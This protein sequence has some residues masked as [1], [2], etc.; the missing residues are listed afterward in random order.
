MVVYNPDLA[1]PFAQWEEVDV[2]FPA[3]AN[4]DLIIR[5][6]LLPTLPEQV[7]YIPIRK[8]QAGDVYHDTT[9]TRVP[10]QLGYI[11]LR[12][13]VASAKVTLLLYVGHP[14]RT[15]VF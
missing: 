8:G 9:G 10:W 12:C 15:V 7:N 5:H 6:T 14:T 4:T 1:Q 2:V 13:S 11:R 3:A